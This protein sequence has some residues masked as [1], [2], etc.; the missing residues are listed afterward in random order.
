MQFRSP[1]VPGLAGTSQPV[2]TWKLRAFAA[3]RRDFD[4]AALQVEGDPPLKLPDIPKMSGV[5]TEDQVALRNAALA[6]RARSGDPDLFVPAGQR[7][8]YEA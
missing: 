1:K 8:R 4:H 6:V 5:P 3:H 7:P 2:M